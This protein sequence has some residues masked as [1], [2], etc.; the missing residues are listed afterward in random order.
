MRRKIQQ[1]LNLVGLTSFL[2]NICVVF[3]F[4]KISEIDLL[5]NFLYEVS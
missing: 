3:F 4:T 2:M 5:V 1:G